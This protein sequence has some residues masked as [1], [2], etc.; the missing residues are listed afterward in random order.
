FYDYFFISFTM[1]APTEIN[2]LSLHDALPIWL[3]SGRRILA[4]VGTVLL[5]CV[6][7]LGA[8][9]ADTVDLRIE[10]FGASRAYVVGVES[11]TLVGTDRKS[12]RRTPVTIRSRMPSSA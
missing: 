10:S 9:R 2:P 3:K 8:A 4:C 6:L 7:T 1:P 5:F 12:T 11:F